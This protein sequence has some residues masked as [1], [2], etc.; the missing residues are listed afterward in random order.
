MKVST[1]G[2]NVSP[3]LVLEAFKNAKALERAG[4]PMVHLSLGQPGREVPKA[5]LERV[6][7][8]MLNDEPLGYTEAAGWLPLRE[9]LQTHYKEF[10]GLDVPLHRIFITVGSSAAFFMSLMTA[11]DKGDKLAITLPC[12]PAYPNIMKAL[13][14]DAVNLRGN[15]ENNFQPTVDMLKALPEAPNGLVIGS[16]SNPSGTMITT[17]ELKN[18]CAYA[19]ENNVRLI[20][21][22]IY[23][24]VTY[25][26]ERGDSILQFT[27][28]GIVIN[29]FSKYFLMPGWR[30]GWAILP[31]DLAPAFEA[32]NQ[33]FFIA[34]P[35]ISQYA[36]YEAME[37][38]D[39][40]KAEV[41]RYRKNREILLAELPK[42]GFDKLAPAEGAFY[43][44][45]DVSGL[46]NDSV[47]FCER[48]QNEIHLS[49]V[50][51]LDFDA[52]DGRSYIR[53]SFA[54]TE[55]EMHETIRRLK[56]WVPTARKAA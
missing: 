46:T 36:A 53:F 12:Y 18:I 54:G 4:H 21:D 30:L 19:E 50:A 37:E 24:G 56:A 40:L 13:E 25:N 6:A 28:T 33:N 23:H 43:I 2:K 34:A 17:D 16:P 14:I 42:C 41:D 8:R 51:G 22:E 52:E 29:S 48:M 9:K 1:R 7:K 31:E 39:A 32:I 3:F 27:Q 11:F 35:A 38:K 20:S 44:Y 15:I 5:V 45:A 26:G 49:P 55:A 47:A 10:Y